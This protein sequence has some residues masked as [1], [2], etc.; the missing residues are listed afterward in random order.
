MSDITQKEKI[1]GTRKKLVTIAITYILLVSLMGCGGRDSDADESYSPA[2]PGVSEGTEVLEDNAVTVQVSSEIE[3]L[4]KGFSAVRYEGEDGFAAFLAG[5]GAKTDQ[6]VVQFLVSELFA[7]SRSGLTMNTQAF[8][9]ST[10][11]VQNTE[12]GYLFGRNFDWNTCDALVV[13]S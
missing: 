3:E 8:G 7:E 13:T 11:S 9:C 6:E 12:G 1:M 5:G 2:R 4:E 10:L